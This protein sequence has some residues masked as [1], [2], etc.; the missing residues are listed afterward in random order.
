VITSGSFQEAQDFAKGKPLE[1][2]DGPELTKTIAGVQKRPILVKD[3][4]KNTLC[5]QCGSAMVLRTAK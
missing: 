2:I 5:P 4:S 3:I 1:L